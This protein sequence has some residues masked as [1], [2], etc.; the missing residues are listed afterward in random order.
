MVNSVLFNNTKFTMKYSVNN[1]SVG[2]VDKP[3]G[4]GAVIF[5]VG[6]EDE[7]GMAE[8]IEVLDLFAV[9][10]ASG[11]HGYSHGG[12]QIAAHITVSVI[13][14]VYTAAELH[15]AYVTVMVVVFICTLGKNL[16]AVVTEMITVCIVTF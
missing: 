7:I 4:N 9:Y 15:I 2:V 12:Q 6:E 8:R 14:L 5:G 13:I 16:G 3:I 10:K 11:I 1:L